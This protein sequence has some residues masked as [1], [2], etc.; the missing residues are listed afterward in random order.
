[1]MNRNATSRPKPAPTVCRLSFVALLLAAAAPADG[2]TLARPGWTASGFNADP[3]WKHAVFYEVKPDTGAIAYVGPAPPSPTEWLKKPAT[4]SAKLDE[5]QS[6]GVDALILPAPARQTTPDPQDSFDELMPQ[7][8][9]RGIHILLTIPASSADGDLMAKARSWLSRGVSGFYV[10]ASPQTDPTDRQ[11]VVG[12]LHKVASVQVGGRIVLADLPTDVDEV[13]D[14]RHVAASPSARAENRASLQLEVDARESLP[15][16]PN[17]TSL[18]HLLEEEPSDATVLVDLQQ[19]ASDSTDPYASLWKTIAAMALTTHPAALIDAD[20][21]LSG[22][23]DVAST[24]LVDWY[25]QLIGLHRGNATL[26]YGSATALNFDRENALVWVSR[27][28]AGTGLAA[29]VVVACNLSSSPI[30]LSLGAAMRGLNLH[31]SFLRTLLRDDSGMG[32]QDLN[33]VMVPAYGVYVGELH[34]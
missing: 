7:A 28:S 21:Q 31:G 16:V 26:R 8:S 29:P 23:N 17:A 30:Y 22:S 11:L 10:T 15:D 3:W 14:R 6:I 24:T 2:Q 34:R 4:I 33:S 12:L 5:L 27:A 20:A 1:M 18:R 9:R 32:P 13:S 25:R 19:P